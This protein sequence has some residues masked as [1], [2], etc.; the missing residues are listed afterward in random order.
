MKNNRKSRVKAAML[1]ASAS[2][3]ALG[4]SEAAVTAVNFLGTGYGAL[5]ATVTADAYGVAVA[6][7]TNQ[8]VGNGA[9]TVTVNGMAFSWTCNNDWNQN[10][11]PSA[12]EG[13]VN[14]GYIDDTGNNSSLTITGISAWLAATPGA[15]AYTIQMVQSSDNATGFPDSA[16]SVS[17]GG[18]ALGTFTNGTTGGGGKLGGATNALTLTSDTLFIEPGDRNGSLRGTIAGVIITSV[19]EPSI[20]ALL[21]LG[22]LALIRRRRR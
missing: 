7:W 13:E 17:D 2:V 12:G 19:P 5:G 16:V 3:A 14:Y 9:G 22:G 6:D 1:V 18:A 15:T 8:D 20:A 4:M 10:G 11:T 21:G